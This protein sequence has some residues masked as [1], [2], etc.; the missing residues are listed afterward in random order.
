MPKILEN[1]QIIIKKFFSQKQDIILGFLR[2]HP[3]KLGVYFREIWA[4]EILCKKRTEF[5]QNRKCP[6]FGGN[7]KNWVFLEIHSKFSQKKSLNS[8]CGIFFVVNLACD[9]LE[10]I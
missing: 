2:S 6:F 8:C 10:M 3:K 9:F 4:E 7:G 5:F 1:R